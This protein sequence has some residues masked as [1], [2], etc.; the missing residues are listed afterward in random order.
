MY[1]AP[2]TTRTINSLAPSRVYGYKR[3]EAGSCFRLALGNA[4]DEL[5]NRR[6]L[7]NPRRLDVQAEILSADGASVRTADSCAGTLAGISRSR[8]S[9]QITLSTGV[10]IKVVNR[11]IST[12]IENS[13]G[14]ITLM[15]TP[16]I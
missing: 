1:P 10:V 5:L 7:S 8:R 6:S 13:A 15:S 3:T 11:A 9:G 4:N 14:E 12:I 2:A 16:I